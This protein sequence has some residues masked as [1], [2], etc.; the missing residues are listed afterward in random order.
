MQQIEA[1]GVAAAERPGHP[2]PTATRP[3]EAPGA[4]GR[5]HGPGRCSWI[6]VANPRLSCSLCLIDADG[7]SSAFVGGKMLCLL[8]CSR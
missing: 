7:F 3:R 5:R 6:N 4:L 8:L 1:L 2:R